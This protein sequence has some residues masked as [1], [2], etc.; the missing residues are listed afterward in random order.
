[1]A[2]KFNKGQQVIGDLVSQDDP[3]RNTKID[4]GDDQINF[5][6]SGTVVAS[7]TPG[8]FSASLYVGDGSSLSGISGGGGGGSG[9]GGSGGTGGNGE[10]EGNNPD[11]PNWETYTLQVE[12]F[13][14]ENGVYLPE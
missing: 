2:F 14:A 12:S 6:V 8:Q 9:S 7:I 11:K 4:F 5:I 3:E 1:M 13:L 10:G